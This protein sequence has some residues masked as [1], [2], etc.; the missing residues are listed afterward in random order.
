MR[1]DELRDNA[2]YI[3]NTG[4]TMWVASLRQS[5]A[6]CIDKC[7]EEIDKLYDAGMAD[8]R[9]GKEMI[10]LLEQMVECYEMLY[11]AEITTKERLAEVQWL[12]NNGSLRDT[13]EI[14]EFCEAL[15]RKAPRIRRRK[16]EQ[17]I[18]SEYRIS[19]IMRLLPFIAASTIGGIPFLLKS[20]TMD[21]AC[22]LS[23]IVTAV[24]F[25]P[26][27]LIFRGLGLA[28]NTRLEYKIY[29][30]RKERGE[31]YQM[32]PSLILDA[33]VYAASLGIAFKKSR[34]K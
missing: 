2:E 17:I 10:D 20:E 9:T 30:G 33:A 32:N 27:L 26:C 25:I 11:N 23:P 6:K 5:I 16:E 4:F 15:D 18:S 13:D 7:E 14:L 8:T 22:F 24:V 19:S 3:G 31:P 21:S 28:L 1:T 12:F 34:K 29:K